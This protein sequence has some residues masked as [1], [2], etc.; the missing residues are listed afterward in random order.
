M[1]TLDHRQHHMENVRDVLS[2]VVYP[3]RYLVN[4]PGAAGE[5]MSESVSTRR[6]LLEE[7]RS[8]HAQ[9]LVLKAQLQKLEA[10]E[11][12]NMRLRELLD[13]AA[14][15]HQR[16]LIAELLAVDMAPFSRQIVINRG[17]RHEVSEGQP[18]LDA[19]GVMG[20]VVEVGPFSSSAMLITDPSHAIPVEINRNGLRAVAKGTGEPNRLELSH[21]PSNADI[22]TGDLLVTS[23]LGGRFPPGYPVARVTRVER[24][25]DQ[26]FAEVD[27]EPSA[28][29]ESTRVILLVMGARVPI[30]TTDNTTAD[31]TGTA[32]Q[33][34]AEK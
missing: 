5:W 15:I 8:L 1:M 31:G 20:Q 27:A 12:E 34:A 13:S 21:L 30:T 6:T 7:N 23:G 2:A 22:E 28:D 14:R 19:N 29:L 18:L 11:A 9:Q 4:L 24:H 25:P 17:G 3:I 10:L 26:P 33:E 32:Q 16:V